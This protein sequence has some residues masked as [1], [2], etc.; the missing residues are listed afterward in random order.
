MTDRL[1]GTDHSACPHV[2]ARPLRWSAVVVSRGLKAGV[3]DST[4]HPRSTHTGLAAA[5]CAILGASLL[6]VGAVL[7]KPV[8]SSGISA[9]IDGAN[10][11][12]DPYQESNMKT[13]HPFRTAGALGVLAVTQIA[14][15]S[16]ASAQSSAVQWRVED[17]GN[18]H[19]YSLASR[20][21]IRL[22]SQAA[23]VA[24]QMGGEPVSI[25]T[26]P[27]W[28]FIRGFVNSVDTND[29]TSGNF[30]IWTGGHKNAS[31]GWVWQWGGGTAAAYFAW[32]SCAPNNP[33]V[34]EV[35]IMISPGWP[36]GAST[37]SW[38]DATCDAWDVD[39]ATGVLIEWSA[40]CNADNV[41]DYGQILDGSLIDENGNGVPD[42]CDLGLSCVSCSACDLNPTGIVD[43][44]DLGA[45]LAFWGPV[46]P[47][48]PR[49]DINRDG[50]VNGADLGLLLANWGPC[51]Q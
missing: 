41:V 19:W 15:V 23:T 44:A 21:G 28:S 22:L 49:A 24:R 17:G 42:C 33:T 11:S 48:F 16:G 36:C 3:M 31:T 13:L 37:T 39:D 8:E 51:G 25:E 38:D 9:R 34:D 27:E 6:A 5:V 47:A 26:A 1:Q 50:N 7:I 45:L 10:G 20:T 29:G 4:P 46:S 18:G 32:N 40:D 30:W 2:G 43:G 14:L 35:V 12:I